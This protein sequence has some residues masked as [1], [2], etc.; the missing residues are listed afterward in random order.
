M[1][2]T[3]TPEGWIWAGRGELK[4]FLDPQRIK[5]TAEVFQLSVLSSDGYLIPHAED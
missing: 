1:R 5:A 2:K 3:G 4:L